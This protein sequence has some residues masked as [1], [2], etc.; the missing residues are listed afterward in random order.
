MRIKEAP[1]L[2]LSLLP[3]IL[4]SNNSCSCS[5]S[6][7]S[8]LLSRNTLSVQLCSELFESFT[9]L[10]HHHELALSPLTH[11]IHN[12]EKEKRLTVS[13]INR[14]VRIPKNMNAAKICIT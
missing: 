5:A 14:V 13:G 3:V 1:L 11:K 4:P 9:F 2:H 7:Q 12:G 10:S 6:S 8:L